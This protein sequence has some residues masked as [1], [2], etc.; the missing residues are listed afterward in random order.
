VFVLNP[1]GMLPDALKG[2]KLAR[3][4]PMDILDPASQSFH[5]MCDKLAAALV[6]T[7]DARACIH[8]GCPDARFGVI[9]AL[10]RH[11]AAHERS[12][13]SGKGHQRNIYGFC[14]LTVQS[15][16]DLSSSK[17]SGASRC[18][19]EAIRE[20]TDRDCNGYHAN[21]AHRNAAIEKV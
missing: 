7:K 15:N 10:M 12:G 19:A 3:F 8:D 13:G 1:F 17:C 6:W 16:N 2:L 11:G 20:V 9:A 4:N 18:G 21:S 5:A 14:R